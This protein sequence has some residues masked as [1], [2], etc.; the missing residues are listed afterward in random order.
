M[1]ASNVFL[2]ITRHL[3]N[4]AIALNPTNGI[5]D[6]T[7]VFEIYRGVSP[8]VDSLV[9]A[10]DLLLLEH[11]IQIE[12]DLLKYTDFI[13][14]PYTQPDTLEFQQRGVTYIYKRKLVSVEVG[15]STTVMCTVKERSQAKE[16]VPQVSEEIVPNEPITV[17][18]TPDEFK[19]LKTQIEAILVRIHRE[20][21]TEKIL[22]TLS[23]FTNS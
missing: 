17:K 7:N 2:L 13:V 15:A 6:N 14:S 22:N 3:N 10:I 18:L 16:R 11:R 8:K 9:D 20:D 23:V 5:V 1:R 4:L 21:M 12:S 19:M